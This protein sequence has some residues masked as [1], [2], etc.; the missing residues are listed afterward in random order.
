MGDPVTV[1]VATAAVGAA[2][3]GSD[4]MAG[5]ATASAQR[6][7]AA[8]RQVDAIAA[9]TRGFQI[10]DAA[11]QQLRSTFGNIDAM[12][13]GRG[14]DVNSGGTNAAIFAKA[15]TKSDR[16]RETAVANTRSEAARAMS[17]SQIL[18]SGADG[19]ELAG[20]LKGSM[21][22]LDAASGISKI[23]F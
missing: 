7:K 12:N 8:Q 21:S 18:A 13:A 19:Y 9:K 2:K 20:L 1:A 11:R 17:D 6:L 16:A 14:V 10:G 22:L 15:L 5:R 23:K 4:I 3:G